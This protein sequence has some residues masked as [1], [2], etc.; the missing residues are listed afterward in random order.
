MITRRYFVDTLILSALTIALLYIADFKVPY[1]WDSPPPLRGSALALGMPAI[2]V[3]KALIGLFWDWIHLIGWP[4]L[5]YG[6]IFVFL[7]L[8]WLWVRWWWDCV[9]SERIQNIRAATSSAVAAL[10]LWFWI[11]A[12]IL[13]FSHLFWRGWFDFRWFLNGSAFIFVW[14]PTISLMIGEIAW[15]AFLLCTAGMMIKKLARKPRHG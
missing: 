4:V 2:L 10:A 11:A 7:V 5:E 9:R 3:A 8:Q 15:C 14:V 6:P 1:H 12:R 13:N